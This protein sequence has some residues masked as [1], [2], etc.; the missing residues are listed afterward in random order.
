MNFL[1]FRI[2]RTFKFLITCLSVL[3]L[4]NILISFSTSQTQ[5]KKTDDQNIVF[6]DLN[7]STNI[8]IDNTKPDK[9][10]L[11]RTTGIEDIISYFDN[12]LNIVFKKYHASIKNNLC[13]SN[14]LHPFIT[15]I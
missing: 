1:N 3:F 5:I 14:S 15:V 4:L 2:K 13:K 10:I 6:L 11:D 7:S 9:R 12:S 8:L